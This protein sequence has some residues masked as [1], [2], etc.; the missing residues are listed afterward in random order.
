MLFTDLVNTKD[1]YYFFIIIVRMQSPLPVNVRRSR[2][3]TCGRRKKERGKEEKPSLFPFLPVPYSFKCYLKFDFLFLFLGERGCR[4]G[5]SARLPSMWPAGFKSRRRCVSY[6]M[7]FLFF[8]MKWFS[9]STP[10]FPSP[11]KLKCPTSK[12]VIYFIILIV[13]FFVVV[14]F[15]LSVFFLPLLLFFIIAKGIRVCQ[16]LKYNATIQAFARA[17][18]KSAA[19]I[20]SQLMSW[21]GVRK[22]S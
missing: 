5:G 4:S 19:F 15:F 11:P 7:L 2:N 1:I 20:A 13:C 16:N 21:L 17:K 10:L 12:I 8:A 3:I 9:P 18:V 22:R 14:A 6:L